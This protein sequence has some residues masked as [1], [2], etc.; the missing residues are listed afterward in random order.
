MH[1]FPQIIY[2]PIAI[3]VKSFCIRHM[4]VESI[5]VSMVKI[6]RTFSQAFMLL[7]IQDYDSNSLIPS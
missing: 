1:F 3:C 4:P 2:T 7:Y 6:K 5:S